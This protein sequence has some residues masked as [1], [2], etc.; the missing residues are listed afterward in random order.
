MPSSDI[1][2]RQHVD[3]DFCFEVPVVHERLL[4]ALFNYY[5][6]NLA[7]GVTLPEQALNCSHTSAIAQICRRGE[8][9]NERDFILRPA[10]DDSCRHL[11]YGS[12]GSD[13]VVTVIYEGKSNDCDARRKAIS[14]AE[15]LAEDIKRYVTTRC[16]STSS[17]AGRI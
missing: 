17:P 15:E 3:F 10:E 7:K 5:A 9:H 14:A 2:T 16:Q 6:E 4:A 11:S 12:A 1:A 13:F 8:R